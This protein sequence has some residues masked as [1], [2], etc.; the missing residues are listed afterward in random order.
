M[1]AQLFYNELARLGQ[2]A[3]TTLTELNGVHGLGDHYHKMTLLQERP[4]G[5]ERFMVQTFETFTRANVPQTN[6]YVNGGYQVVDMVKM[7]RY[8]AEFWFKIVDG[9]VVPAGPETIFYIN[10][11][12]AYTIKAQ[13]PQECAP[14]LNHTLMDGP[15]DAPPKGATPTC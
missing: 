10:V 7:Y 3:I 5:I 12:P 4:D 14:V 1:N 15:N 6:T 13:V 9:S 11:V 8:K 2:E